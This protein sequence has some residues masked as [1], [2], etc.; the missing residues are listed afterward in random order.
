MEKMKFP[1]REVLKFPWV[2]KD[3]DIGFLII[4]TIPH[5]TAEVAEIALLRPT[6]IPISIGGQ[7]LMLNG[8]VDIGSSPATITFMT[9]ITM[10]DL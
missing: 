2:R 9:N 3:V 1:K 8:E 7:E 5:V 4:Y 10:V 6:T